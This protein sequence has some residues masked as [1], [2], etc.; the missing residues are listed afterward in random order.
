MNVKM[1]SGKIFWIHVLVLLS[2]L[3]LNGC[4]EGDSDSSSESE[5]VGK[6]IV[7]HNLASEGEDTSRMVTI[8]P[9]ATDFIISGLGADGAI[10]YGPQTRSRAD[11]HQLDGVSGNV[12]QINVEYRTQDGTLHAEGNASVVV[13]PGDTVGVNALASKNLTVLLVNDSEV[14]D[15]DVYILLS[16]N[17]DVQVET[18]CGNGTGELS[19]LKPIGTLKSPVTGK[20]NKVYA[21]NPRKVD[22]GRL[23][24][25]YKQPLTYKKGDNAPTSLENVRYDKMELGY[26]VGKNDDIGYFD[27][28][29]VDFFGI[30]LQMEVMADKGDLS[31]FRTATFYTST[32]TL[33]KSLYEL[34]PTEMD[35]A[36]YAKGSTADPGW[37]PGTHS[38]E[39]F[40]RVM[41]PLTLASEVPKDGGAFSAVP[42]P[43]FRNYLTSLV[44]NGVAVSFKGE[45]GVDSGT[46]TK[47]DYQCSISS[48]GNEGFVVT[49]KP[50]SA[51]VNSPMGTIGDKKYPDQK[52]PSDLAVNMPLTE[53][54]L[55]QFVY[56]VPANS[57]SVKNLDCYL[58]P[59][60][61]NS[62]YAD[63]AGNFLAALSFGYVNGRYGTNGT[64]WFDVLPGYAPYGAAR[65][66]EDGYYN[67]Y[68]AVL[69]NLSDSYS[70]SIS[71]RLKVGN[72]LL[73]TSPQKPYMRVTILPDDRLN[74]PQNV[75]VTGSSN[76]TLTVE[77]DKLS[78]DAA[79]GF[80]LDGYEVTAADGS[81]D[82]VS[83]HKPFPM[84]VTPS[85]TVVNVD[86]S[87]H[88][89]TLTGLNPGTCYKVTVAAVGHSD[90][91]KSLRSTQGM[92]AS[93]ATDSGSA[94]VSNPGINY[95]VGVSPPDGMSSGIEFSVDGKSV[96]QTASVPVSKPKPANGT[97]VQNLFKITGPNLDIEKK[98]TVT[99]AQTNILFNYF[100]AGSN[101]FN[102]YF[103]F[104][105][106]NNVPKSGDNTELMDGSG[107]NFSYS[108]TFGS[109][110]KSQP[111]FGDKANSL[112]LN[113]TPEPSNTPKTYS[114]VDFPSG[115]P[116]PLNP[117]PPKPPEPGYNPPV[118]NPVDCPVFK[119][120]AVLKEGSAQDISDLKGSTVKIKR[121][122]T[123]PVNIHGI[124]GEDGSGA[125]A[126]GTLNATGVAEF[127]PS[128]SPYNAPVWDLGYCVEIDYNGNKYKAY[129]GWTKSDGTAGQEWQ[130]G[131]KNKQ[132]EPGIIYVP[133]YNALIAGDKEIWGN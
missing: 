81:V 88:S 40:L 104:P 65:R 126:A 89:A 87:K 7:H 130:S 52:L 97:L 79:S 85:Q 4:I 111:P 22:S 54:Y 23:W 72:P 124:P 39:H 13:S 57:F 9:E 31:P 56:G 3:M 113:V 78:A 73:T 106:S 66:S 34:D 102:P 70:F 14:D 132:D 77:W 25:S 117:N 84:N 19:I 58:R 101:S 62:V 71:D 28:T 109:D 122:V 32:T 76:D 86:A 17:G 33:L 26:T 119:V 60:A 21:F 98:N 27:L 68:A 107:L 83:P 49:C 125:D 108:P 100:D 63:I 20:T 45:N 121:L 94:N 110:S 123:V 114:K 118:H 131:L 129:G 92:F 47:W 18:D 64:S 5:T 35:K 42:Y 46:P 10:L 50:K 11:K 95:V 48:D 24:I 43:S 99:Y 80:H 67:P 51:M 12:K 38:M 105:F 30:P 75:R 116:V 93:A 74:A 29:S 8:G 15:E 96:T 53:K 90:A 112:V 41:S 59:Y 36:F 44:N 103:N 6:V 120:Q 55:D 115:T 16:A 69:Y 91:H 61:D 2:I 82:V 127:D 128:K 37:I 133:I 1:L